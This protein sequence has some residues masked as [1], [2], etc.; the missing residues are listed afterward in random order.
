M[1][2]NCVES[3]Y[4]DR[5]GGPMQEESLNL[6]RRTF[7]RMT[8]SGVALAGTRLLL[9]SFVN[10]EE[11]SSGHRIAPEH[12]IELRSPEL[13]VTFDSDDGVPYEFRMA[14]NHMRGEGA[15]QPVSM[16]ICKKEGWD[17]TD[18]PVRAKDF[19]ESHGAISFAFEGSGI[20]FALRYSLRQQTL[21]VMLDNIEESADDEL[22]SVYLP[23]LVTVREEDGPAWLVHG[24]S[25][26]SLTMLRDSAV[27]SL[28]PNQFWGS[29]LGTLPVV[30]VGTERM[31][32][33]QET[34]AY[35]DGT[36][37]TV[38]GPV[39]TRRASLGTIKVHRVDGGAC[40]D[41][42]LGK[43]AP[44]DCGTAR[45]PNLLV[46]QQSSCRLDFLPVK[47]R[48]EDA[49]LDAAKLVRSRM[50]AIPNG[51]YHDKYIYGIRCDEPKSAKPAATFTECATKIRDI[52][53]LIDHSPQIVHLWGWQFRGKD[54]GYPAVNQVNERL[55][56]Y[57]S[58]MQLMEEGQKCNTTVT[59]SDNYDDAYRSSPAWRE[60]IIARK[61]DG[62]LWKSR[63]WTGEDSY[64][65]GMAKYVEASRLERVR[66]TCERYKLPQTTHIDVL[67]YFAIRNDWD[68][69][70][71]ASGIRNLVEGRYRILQE[72]KKR[73]VDVSS[74][75]LRYPMIGHISC[76]WYAQGPGRC[77][78]GG[79]R[80]PLL[81]LIYR[82][83]A[84]WGLSGGHAD[85]TTTRL[86]ELFLGASPR[87]VGLTSSDDKT[88][89]DLFYLWLVP[90]FETH[91]RNIESFRTEGDT[92]VIGLEGQSSIEI[93][94]A[95]Q[96]HRIVLDGNEIARTGR[97]MCPLGK[98][99]IAFYSVEREILRASIP[100]GW[101]PTEMRAVSIA[102]AKRTPVSWEI[103]GN[104]VE[105]QVSEQ[106]PVIVYRDEAT[107]RLFSNFGFGGNKAGNY[108]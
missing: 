83:S 76:F 39:G 27:G 52:A 101:D 20:R 51:F 105:I 12:P 42:N 88:V 55:G 50:P 28:P 9:P 100:D 91:L 108:S 18:V 32:C 106:Q 58:M 2:A 25:G 65:I 81:P 19:T 62:Q 98:D 63:N 43:D 96:T 75:A 29:V 67:S 87:A 48:I 35:M 53:A 86:N 104:S 10:A 56:G 7:L 99:R 66:Y 54:T 93:D 14:G 107:M 15:G 44:R 46:E 41:M 47:G 78:F 22:I 68:P 72:F 102:P 97:T 37:L 94:W 8:G 6:N 33:V 4:I 64:I 95:K 77:P 31:M 17:F 13:E 5:R 85:A 3:S 49:W 1:C 40:Y 103:V 26:G 79:R 11:A 45:T 30:M 90:W 92:T 80:I 23:S 71:P 74:E 16:R 36:L 57:D 61:P 59:L 38:A 89:T 21:I 84:V 60:G 34:T 24:D 73:G 69:Q 82:N 70:R